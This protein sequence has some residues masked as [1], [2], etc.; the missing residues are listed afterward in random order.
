MKALRKAL[1]GRKVLAFMDL[2]ATQFSHEII[3][4]G[5]IK[6]LLND[7]LTVKKALKGLKIYVKPKGKIGDLVS[8]LTGITEDRIEKEGVR[9]ARAQ[10]MVEDYLG[11]DYRS[12]LFVTYGNQDAMMFIASAENNLDSDIIAARDISHRCFDFEAFFTRYVSGEHGNCLSL[13]NA[14][15]VFGIEEKERSHDALTDAKDLLL[16]YEAFLKEK[17]KVAEKYVESLCH[18]GKGPGPIRELVRRV[19]EGQQVGL[20]DLRELALRDIA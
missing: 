4:I 9:F 18:F 6:V 10:K 2:E 5:L 3:E 8:R 14:L 20:E 13:T 11:K 1:G 17:E 15:K 19:A 7:D 16:L 12:C